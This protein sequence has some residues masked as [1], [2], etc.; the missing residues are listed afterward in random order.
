MNGGHSCDF[1]LPPGMPMSPSPAYECAA[2]LGEESYANVASLKRVTQILLLEAQRYPKCTC[3][4]KTKG[5][6]K[7]AGSRNS[8]WDDAI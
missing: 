4:Q 5:S 2:L 3:Y 8:G 7:G 6:P 1:I